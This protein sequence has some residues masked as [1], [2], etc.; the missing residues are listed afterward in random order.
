M[1]ASAIGVALTASSAAHL[2]Q[3]AEDTEQKGERNS[4][5]LGATSITG[6]EQDNTSYQ[7]RKASCNEVAAVSLRTC[8]GTTVT[9]RG[10][11]TSG[12]VYFCDEAFSTW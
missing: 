7:V 10:V 9:E 8:C 3:A 1:L 5:S 4:I 2:A 12:A 6:Q 11:S